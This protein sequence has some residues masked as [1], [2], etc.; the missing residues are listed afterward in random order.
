MID[1]YCEVCTSVPR[2]NLY[3]FS[4]QGDVIT[5][6]FVLSEP[7]DHVQWVIDELAQDA[8]RLLEVARGRGTG[9]STYRQSSAQAPDEVTERV[10]VLN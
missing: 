10:P 8:E 5:V 2:E 6:F 7:V 1:S 9:R 4:T 3:L